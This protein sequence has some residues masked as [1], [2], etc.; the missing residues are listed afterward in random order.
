[1]RLWLIQVKN[2]SCLHKKGLLYN[3]KYVN[4]RFSKEK[5]TI[6]TH[7]SL[8]NFKFNNNYCKTFN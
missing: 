7:I 1:M 5:N 2:T 3:V 4:K 8:V 6:L